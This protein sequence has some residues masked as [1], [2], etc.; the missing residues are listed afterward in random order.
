MKY[1][2]TSALP[3][4]NNVP[5]LGNLIGSTLSADFYARYCRLRG[6]ETLFVC[7]SDC[8]GTASEVKAKQAG[9]SPAELCEKYHQIHKNVYAWFGISFDIYGK[10]TTETHAEIVKEISQDLDRHNYLSVQQVQQLYCQKC[11]TCLADRYVVGT[12]PYCSKFAKGDQCDDSACGKVLHATMLVDPQC[13]LCGNKPK[14]TTSMHIFLNLEKSQ[15]VIEE[16]VATNVGWSENSVAVTK[17]WLKTGLHARCITRDL[18]WGT[19]VPCLLSTEWENKVFYVWYDAPIGYISITACERKDWKDWWQNP[20]DTK[21]YQFMAKDNIPFHTV[22]FPATLLATQKPWTLVTNICATEYLNFEG[23]KFSKSNGVGIF[24]DEIQ[25]L[26][27]PADYWRYYL[28]TIRPEKSDSNFD[29]KGFST[30]IGELA[31]KYGNLVYRVLSLIKKYSAGKP[32]TI[33]SLQEPEQ[34]FSTLV[35]KLYQNYLCAFDEVKIVHAVQIAMNIA[36]ETNRYLYER[37]P[38]KLKEDTTQRDNICTIALCAA[39]TCSVLLSPVIPD[40]H[41][42]FCRQLGISDNQILGE[43]INLVNILNMEKIRITDIKPL[44]DKTLNTFDKI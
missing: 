18:Y 14:I 23:Q 36:Q 33:S 25:E 8:Y 2:I 38:W 27:I 19:P 9:I 29:C 44:V 34:V 43:S 40:I 15:K 39:Y 22:M 24:C 37:E 30:A 20:D 42:T 3:Y 16:W 35:S 13:V 7:G 26:E 31:D 6:R 28:A 5:H 12:C 32:A 11:D 4:V 1:L 21:L 41:K 17:A 10:T